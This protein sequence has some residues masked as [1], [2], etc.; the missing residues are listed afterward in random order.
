[1]VTAAFNDNL[2]T[3][4]HICLQEANACQSSSLRTSTSG[5]RAARRSGSPFSRI[6]IDYGGCRHEAVLDSVISRNVDSSDCITLIIHATICS[7][8][9]RTLLYSNLST[10][11]FV[12][13][14]YSSTCAEIL[15]YL[16]NLSTFASITSSTQNSV[17]CTTAH[18]RF[19]LEPA[20]ANLSSCLNL[21]ANCIISCNIHLASGD[22][23][24]NS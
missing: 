16:I 24:A 19:C 23:S 15:P 13:N 21:I 9:L 6:I 8:K 12:N 14:I 1:M 4:I 2:R 18:L 5:R 7:S 11:S 3:V 20:L 17:Q 10:I 22:I